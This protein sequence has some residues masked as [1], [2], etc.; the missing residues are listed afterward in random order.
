LGW[1]NSLAFRAQDQAG[2]SEPGIPVYVRASDCDK[3]DKEIIK[4]VLK[5][6]VSL[7]LTARDIRYRGGTRPFLI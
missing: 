3:Y 1:R 5:I 4:K 2:E 7:V 6:I